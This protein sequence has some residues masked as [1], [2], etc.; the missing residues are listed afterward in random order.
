MEV[1]DDQMEKAE[2]TFPHIPPKTKEAYYYRQVFEKFYPG[3]AKWLSHY[4]MPRWISAT[5]PSARTLSFYK[6]DKD[7]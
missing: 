6:P 3:Q 2:K 1:N 5:D 4:W 7:Q